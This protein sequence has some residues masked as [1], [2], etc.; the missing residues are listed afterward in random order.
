M[1]LRQHYIKHL[2]QMYYFIPPLLDDVLTF[3]AYIGDI[4]VK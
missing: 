1:S 3:I 4:K 2:L